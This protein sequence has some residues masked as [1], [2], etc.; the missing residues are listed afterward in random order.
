MP[1]TWL[2]VLA[3]I[4]V[5]LAFASAG[6]IVYDIYGRG[7][8]QRMRIMEVVWPV[9]ALY[10]S[11]LS[12]Y[13]YGRWGRTSTAKWI[14]REGERTRSFG[15]RVAVGVTHCG[16]GCT[17]G[18]IIGGWLVFLIA[19]DILGSRLLGEY[20]VDYALAFTLGI[21]FQYL[22]IKPMQN[23]SVG[24]GVKEAVKVDTLSLTS[25][26]VGL[27]GWMALMR[28]VFFTDPNLEPDQIEYW[29]LMQVGMML[30][31]VTAYPVN[32]WLIRRG[33]KPAM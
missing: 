30:G 18:D 21:L 25:F 32:W 22:T 20:V 26:E 11:V 2:T 9:T 4:W 12:L 23:L 16:S 17:L 5:G 29:F 13:G 7:Y 31:F 24:A 27:F 33:V 15:A 14:A 19:I 3:W 1:P 10:F 6:W 8:R 28:L